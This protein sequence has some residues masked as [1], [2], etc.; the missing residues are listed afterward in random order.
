M[1]SDTARIVPN[2]LLVENHA[3]LRSFW[4]ELLADLGFTVTAAES[5][6]QAQAIIQSGLTVDV[7]F[8]DIRMPGHLDGLQLA[9]W[10]RKH[11]P[12]IIILLQTGSLDRLPADFR[13]L[14]KPFTASDFLAN[15][16]AAMS[17][18]DKPGS[19][20]SAVTR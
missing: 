20:A 1:I 2:L 3:P 8:S 18:R 5:G 14:R 19:G 10:V 7:V 4:I 15:L 9:Y 6:D 16:Q 11:Y 13:I 17:E 12:R